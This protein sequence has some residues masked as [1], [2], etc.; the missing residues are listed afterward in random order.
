MRVVAFRWVR[1]LRQAGGGLPRKLTDYREKRSERRAVPA[2]AGFSPNQAHLDPIAI[3]S[4]RRL[5]GV[6]RG[7]RGQSEKRDDDEIT[8]QQLGAVPY[9]FSAKRQ[10][11]ESR[12]H[13]GEQKF[14]RQTL[15][16][17]TPAR[18]GVGSND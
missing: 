2:H 4:L 1:V 10:P 16:G 3:A 15:S 17:S 13:I 6:D 18:R 5:I 8:G 12:L 9:L 7:D 11:I 14:W